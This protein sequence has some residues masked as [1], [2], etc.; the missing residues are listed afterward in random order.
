MV[1]VTRDML[2]QRMRT[3]IMTVMHRYR[4]RVKGWDVV[5]EGG[6]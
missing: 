5:N 1:K 3:H 4:R 2:I 6:N